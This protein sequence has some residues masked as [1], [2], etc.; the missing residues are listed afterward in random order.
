MMNVDSVDRC[1]GSRA[2]ALPKTTRRVSA[3]N[4][5]RVGQ[6]KRARGNGVV[7][8]CRRTTSTPT[9]QVQGG[10]AA[11]NGIEGGGVVVVVDDKEEGVHR[12]GKKVGEEGGALRP[13]VDG[14]KDEEKREDHLGLVKALLSAFRTWERQKS[15]AIEG[16]TEFAVGEAVEVRLLD[17]EGVY[18]EIVRW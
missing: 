12:G 1:A 8:H 3:K 16:L 11:V 9:K 17:V 18:I 15:G 14:E 4:T 13:V 5:R 6:P 2:Q 7:V 10:E